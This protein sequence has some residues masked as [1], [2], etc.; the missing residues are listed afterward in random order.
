[1]VELSL[2]ENE[3]LAVKYLRGSTVDTNIVGKQ[4][5]NPRK[6]NFEDN[7]HKT[8]APTDLIFFFKK[9]ADA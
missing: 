8:D 1:M 5:Q 7:Q 2:Q 3:D 4:T 9:T 6:L